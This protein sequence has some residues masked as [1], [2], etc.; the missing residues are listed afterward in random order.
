VS[1]HP[2]YRPT[3]YHFEY[4]LTDH[5]GSSTTESPSVGSDNAVHPV[6][7][8]ISNLAPLTLYHFRVVATNAIGVTDG[9]DQTFSTLEGAPVVTLPPP[10]LTCKK[11][12]VKR[13]GRCVRK[14]S[15]KR[16]R[17]RR[18]HQ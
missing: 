5:Y 6:S 1:I 8:S 7:A 16:K 2:G 11:G 17:H 18:S 13:Q 10:T 15:H 12:F 9:P 4:G 3:T 14:P